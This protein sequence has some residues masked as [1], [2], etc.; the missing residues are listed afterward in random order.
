[1]T[2]EKLSAKA[3]LEVTRKNRVRSFPSKVRGRERLMPFAQVQHNASFSFN[4]SAKIFTAGSCFARNIERALRFINFDVVSSP[5]DIAAPSSAKAVFQLYNKFTIHSILNELKWA[6][7]AFHHAPE[8]LLYEV[9]DGEYCDMQINGP[10]LI[11]SKAEML[12]FRQ[13]FNDT[14]KAAM[15]ADVIIITLGLVE[16]WYDTKTEL[17]LNVA[18][19]GKLIERYPDRFEFHVLDYDDISSALEEMYAL[20][21]KNRKGTLKLLITVSPVGLASTF[22]G[23]D[24]LVANTY[25]KA[26]Q[27]AAVEKFTMKANVDYFPS[28]EFVT[29][30][31]HSYAW[32]NLDFRHVRKETVDRIMAQ[33]LERY[34]GRNEAQSTLAARGHATAHLNDGNTEKAIEILD[35]HI[36]KYGQT[37]ELMM[38]Y[39]R[40]LMQARRF[41]EAYT[42]FAFFSE[43]SEERLEKICIAY[44]DPDGTID[45]AARLERSCKTS[46]SRSLRTTESENDVANNKKLEALSIIDSFDTKNDG[47]RDLQILRDYVVDSYQFAQRERARPS[48]VVTSLRVSAALDTIRDLVKRDN[49]D[50]AQK[51]AETALE[52]LD[53]KYGDLSLIQMELA[54][55]YQQKGNIAEALVIFQVLANTDGNFAL[56]A[57][58]RAVNLARKLGN[59]ELAAELATKAADNL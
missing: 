29:L 54:T 50:E 4:K 10:A 52:E 13:S 47:A 30:S 59:L 20:L 57:T 49:V 37:T 6:V 48:S 23:Q 28:Y 25:S 42:A 14:F 33:V 45:L 34:T 43:A 9:E 22:R 7:G 26:V 56:I 27:R 40:G 32:G 36:Q 1:M 44:D 5:V 18:P 17:Y 53:G 2:V 8:D 58:R 24:V 46:H 38:I 21:L 41:K 55:I 31:D 51:V 15:S 3:A 16:C 12:A 19:G 11:G 39:A 35:A